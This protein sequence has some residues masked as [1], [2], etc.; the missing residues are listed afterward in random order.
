M[1]RGATKRKVSVDAG[2]RRRIGLVGCVKKKAASAR[3]AEELYISALF[4]GRAA[5]VKKSCDR[6]FIFSARH[7]LLDPG[8]VLEPYDVTL[9][10]AS[11]ERLRAWS[12]Q[13]L[14]QLQAKLGDFGSCEFEIHAGVPYRNFGLVEGL[15]RAGG[16]VVN[17][18]KGLGIERQRSFS[19]SPSTKRRGRDRRT[20][21]EGRVYQRREGDR[22]L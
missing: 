12:H 19:S 14:E 9:G 13:V 11:R 1:Y 6:W 21:V 15:P 20:A 10:H 17:P 16:T 18:T 2:P 4:C 22:C 7:G 3:R 8:T 5:Y